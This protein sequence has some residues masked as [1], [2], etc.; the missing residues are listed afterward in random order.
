MSGIDHRSTENATLGP[1]QRQG[2]KPQIMRSLVLIAVGIA[3]LTVSAKVKLALPLVPMTLQTLVV[4]MIGAAYGTRLGAATVA[5][6]LLAGLAGLPVFAG[7]VGGIAPFTG[8][9]GGYLIGFFVAAIAMGLMCERG[10]AR[11]MLRLFGAMIIGHVILL[12]IGFLW[13]AYG[14]RLGVEK[15]FFSGTVPFL[16]GAL[17]KSALGAVLVRRATG[18]TR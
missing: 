15:A 3:L 4:L 5:L 6:Y 10:A 7:T 2:G 9:T 8:P 18:R 16:A 14:Y 1:W 11:S 12:T 13:L 17:V